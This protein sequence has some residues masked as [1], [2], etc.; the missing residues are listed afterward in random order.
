MVNLTTLLVTHTT[1][2]P[3]AG[4]IVTMNWQALAMKQLWF[5]RSGN[6]AIV[7]GKEWQGSRCDVMNW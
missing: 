3:I 1:Q 5:A 4:R 2:H 6:E 7:I